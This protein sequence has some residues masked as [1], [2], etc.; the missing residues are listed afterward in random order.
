MGRLIYSMMI[1]LDGYVEDASGGFD[2]AAPDDEVHAYANQLAAPI[3]T[4]LYGRRMYETMVYWETAHTLPDQQQVELDWARQWQASEKIV[5]SRSLAEVSSARTR[6]E[7]EFDPAALRRLKEAAE[8]DLA[9][10][11]PGLAAAALRAGLVDEIQPIIAPVAV[12]G[13]KRFLPADLRLDLELI[14]E[15]R[16]ASGVVALRYNVRG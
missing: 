16:F 12:G 10:S 2:W 5:Y 1:S 11:G 9:V 14:E 6:I 8:R 15:R 13:G 4:N 7:R 3:G